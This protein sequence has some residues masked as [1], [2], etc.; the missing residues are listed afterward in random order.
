M[1]AQ[2]TSILGGGIP[3][4]HKVCSS[5]GRGNVKAPEPLISQ[6]N[7]DWT[8][9]LRKDHKWVF[10]RTLY[11]TWNT[12]TATWRSARTC[13]ALEA[14]LTAPAATCGQIPTFRRWNLQDDSKSTDIHCWRLTDF[15]FFPSLRRSPKIT[16]HFLCFSCCFQWFWVCY[17]CPFKTSPLLG[18]LKTMFLK[19][20]FGWCKHGKDTHGSSFS[21]KKL[22]DSY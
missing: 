21:A 2:F 14:F 5:A 11:V 17:E 3:V 18:G 12:S 19:Q 7:G 22:V 9:A 10:A 16:L 6:C 8:P 13:Q 1:L 20:P 15:G 4:G